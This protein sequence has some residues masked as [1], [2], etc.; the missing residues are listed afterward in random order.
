MAE[1]DPKLPN[2]DEAAKKLAEDQA[3]AEKSAA[4]AATRRRLFAILAGVIAVAAIGYAIYWFIVG[5]NNV[6]TDNAYVGADSALVT[7]LTA[8]AIVKVNVMETQRVRAGDVL[9]ELDPSDARVALAQAQAQLATA[10]R[11]VAGYYAQDRALAAQVTSRAADIAAADARIASAESD[12]KRARIDL[13]RRQA[14]VASGAVSGDELSTAQNRFAAALAGVEQARAARLQATAQVTAAKGSQAVNMALIS[15]TS[16]Q[17]NPEIRAARAMV[18]KAQLDLDRTIIRAPL[19]GVV[20]KKTVQ[21]G[22]RV[23]LGTPLMSIVPVETAYVD[24]NFKEGQLRKVR[25][26]Q[27][28]TLTSDLYGSD[29]VYHGTVTG[30]SGGTGAAFALIPAQNATGNWIKVVQRLPV[31]ISLKADELRAH[32]LRIGLSMSAEIDISNAN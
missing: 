12:L 26:G 3:R 16:G 27:P 14:L 20:A 1:A 23:A 18:E 31:R 10:T 21:I 9:V 17:E 25:I 4:K 8:A 22:Q 29:V 7:P 19:S 30:L 24:A 15:D 5:R 28:V 6:S 32:P 2:V 11:K 13:S